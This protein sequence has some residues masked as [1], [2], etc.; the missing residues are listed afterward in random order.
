MTGRRWNVSPCP[1]VRSI[2]ALR[3]LAESVSRI[4]TP[5]LAQ[6]SVAWMLDTRV[7]TL[8]SPDIGW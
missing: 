5:P 6:A 1:D 8:V 4:I 3:E 7:V 2:P